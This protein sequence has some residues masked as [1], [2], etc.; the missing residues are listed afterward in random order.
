MSIK[1]GDLVQ[2][3][4]RRNPGIALVLKH[5]I[6]ITEKTASQDEFFCFLKKWC[7]GELDVKTKWLAYDEFLRHS[8]LQQEE[9]DSFLRYNKLHYW[10]SEFQRE[11]PDG[12]MKEFVYVRWIKPASD[13]TNNRMRYKTAWFPANWFKKAK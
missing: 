2:L 10:N 7:S 1:I 4:R 3:Y 9:I 5:T 12:L 13:Y 6:D 11:I 8:G